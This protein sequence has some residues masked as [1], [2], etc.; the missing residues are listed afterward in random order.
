MQP[1]CRW[2][3]LDAVEMYSGQKRLTLVLR[4]AGPWR[5]VVGTAVF[6]L[7]SGW[8]RVGWLLLLCQVGFDV[9]KWYRV[10]LQVQ[11]G[12]LWGCPGWLS[13]LSRLRAGSVSKF[14]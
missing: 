1:N 4:E 14:T 6:L 3:C 9:G 7:C 5:V 8:C 11:I 2:R 12:N 10:L 13:L